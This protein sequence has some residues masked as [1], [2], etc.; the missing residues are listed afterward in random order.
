MAKRGKKWG[1][2][3]RARWVLPS[4][5]LHRTAGG[6][7]GSVQKTQKIRSACG[8]RHQSTKIR[9]GCPSSP[10]LSP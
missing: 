5:S 8:L 4:P 10:S 9:S 1:V 2:A 7:G 6:N 3:C